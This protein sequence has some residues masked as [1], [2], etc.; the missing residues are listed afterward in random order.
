MASGGVERNGAGGRQSTRANAPARSTAAARSVPEG[1]PSHTL[2][3]P[4]FL[5]AAAL[6]AIA[7]CDGDGLADKTYPPADDYPEVTVVGLLEAAYGPDG[8]EPGRYNVRAYVGVVRECPG[9]AECEVPPC[10]P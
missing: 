9:D 3:R 5:L 6:A 2:M 1:E 8:V 7:G 4:S 10:P